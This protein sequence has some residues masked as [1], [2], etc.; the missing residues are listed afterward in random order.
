MI[1]K[2]MVNLGLEMLMEEFGEEEVERAI[3]AVKKFGIT[4]ELIRR[5]DFNGSE[6]IFSY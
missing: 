2:R 3:E 4:R 5:L 6:N 1:K